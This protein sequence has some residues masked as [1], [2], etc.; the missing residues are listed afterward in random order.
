MADEF[1]QMSDQVKGMSQPFGV[2]AAQWQE[3]Q[4]SIAALEA[5]KLDIEARVA[6]LEKSASAGDA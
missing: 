2:S 6:A 3:L 4:G 5:F 1:D